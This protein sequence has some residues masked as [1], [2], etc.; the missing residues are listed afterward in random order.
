MSVYKEFKWALK[1]R[2]L[3]TFFNFSNT[4]L[5]YPLS[6]P[7]DA[8][9]GDVDTVIHGGAHMG[10]ERIYYLKSNLNV[11]WVEAN[12]YIFGILKRN[13]RFYRNQFPI[14]ATLSDK[15]GELVD[16]KISKSTSAS[17]TLDFKDLE[18][19][20]NHEHVQ[21]ITTTTATV[22][23]LIESNVIKLGLRN[24]LLC[25][26]QGT[27][28]EVIKG[29]ES[30]SDQFQYVIAE[31]QDYELYKNQSLS[32]EIE[33]YLANKGFS[34]IKKEIWASNASKTKNCY[35]LVF[36]RN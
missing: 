17:S 15:A 28:L 26:T 6:S 24:L 11:Y 32:A 5:K 8:Y 36:K 34:L 31:S 1:K 4:V 16:F 2:L 25:D 20:P 3:F 33:S 27:E 35:E 23:N 22:A 29:A 18:V 13:L 7:E 30:Y 19:T 9:F 14:M 21:T 10:E 12:P